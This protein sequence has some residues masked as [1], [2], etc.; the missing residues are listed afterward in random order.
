MDGIP[1]CVHGWFQGCRHATLEVGVL[2]ISHKRLGAID[3]IRHFIIKEVVFFVF[4]KGCV[5]STVL[6]M[7]T[8]QLSLVALDSAATMFEPLS[9]TYTSLL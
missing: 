1:A 4:S 6:K 9:F 5:C 8:P 7:C 3:E 2:K